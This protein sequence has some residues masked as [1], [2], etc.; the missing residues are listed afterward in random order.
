MASVSKGLLSLRLSYQNPP[1]QICSR[2]LRRAQRVPHVATFRTNQHRLLSVFR[3]LQQA[4]KPR[5]RKPQLQSAESPSSLPE[6]LNRTLKGPTVI[7]EA[8]SHRTLIFAA[9]GLGVFFVG[10]GVLNALQP[11]VSFI[12]GSPPSRKSE[13]RLHWVITSGLVLAGVALTG[14]GVWCFGAARNLVKRITVIPQGKAGPLQA[15]VEVTG[16]VPLQKKTL[17]PL[18]LESLTLARKLA[19]IAPANS[20]QE[21][22]HQIKD[23]PAVL[24]PFL[25]VGTW[26]RLFF[27]DTRNVFFRAPFVTLAVDGHGRYTLD[28]RGSAYQGSTGLDRLIPADYLKGKF[29]DRTPI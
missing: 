18:P 27:D 5:L 1:S 25:R 7:Y 20:P 11:G 8:P 13:D 19:E 23:A 16:L 4:P 2:C 26:T 9:S 12:F 3:T 28:S 29:W 21:R 24:R 17:G 15:T 14:I 10:Y 22:A 6:Q